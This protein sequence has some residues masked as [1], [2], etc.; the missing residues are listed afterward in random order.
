MKGY[1]S[2]LYTLPVNMAGLP[3]FTFFTGYSETG[4][5]VGLQLVGP[6]WSDEALLDMG[7]ELEKILGAPK[8]AA[9]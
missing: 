3:G 5:P 4:L 6:R 1:E 8:I 9:L 7:F 2:D